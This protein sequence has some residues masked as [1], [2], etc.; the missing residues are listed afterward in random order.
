VTGIG[1]VL[2]NT[3]ELHFKLCG[4]PLGVAKQPKNMR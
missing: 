2:D 1:D 3:F 4:H